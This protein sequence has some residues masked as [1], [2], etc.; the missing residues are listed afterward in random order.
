MISE[1]LHDVSYTLI[2]LAASGSVNGLQSC[3]RFCPD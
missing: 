1:N 2:G 3:K